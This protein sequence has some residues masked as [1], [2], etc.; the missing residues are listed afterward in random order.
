MDP[1]NYQELRFREISM[2][3]AFFSILHQDPHFSLLQY[4]DNI[5]QFQKYEC[6]K[7]LHFLIIRRH[8]PRIAHSQPFRMPV[9]LVTDPTQISGV[10][11]KS[12]SGHI[13][14]MMKF[15][16]PQVKRPG[17]K[18]NYAERYCEKSCQANQLL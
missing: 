17:L 11:G 1:V 7:E 2:T 13:A 16:L 5:D 10:S 9:Q 15:H 18:K 14:G 6:I 4:M 8:K 3:T 12:A